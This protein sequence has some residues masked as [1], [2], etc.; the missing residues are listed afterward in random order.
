VLGNLRFVQHDKYFLAVLKKVNKTN[1]KESEQV[2]F[3][4]EETRTL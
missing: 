2:E 1:A 3:V 4:P